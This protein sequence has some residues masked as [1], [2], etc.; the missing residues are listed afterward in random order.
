MRSPLP[1]LAAALL[2]VLVLFAGPAAAQS[3]AFEYAV[4][5]VCGRA[6]QQFL[7]AGTYATTV[8]VHNPSRETTRFQ[9]KVAVAA[10]MRGDS[11]SGFQTLGLRPDGALAITCRD[12]LGMV[13][14]PFVDGFV[15]IQTQIDMDVTAVYS[16]AGTATGSVATMDIERQTPRRMQ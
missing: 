3:F 9:V 5:V 8:N 6:N 1:P 2:A 16:A 11:I 15:V 12:I 14:R 7:V 4:K 13:G 10:P